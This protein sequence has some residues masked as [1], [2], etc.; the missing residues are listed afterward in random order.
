MCQP[1]ANNEPETRRVIIAGAGP[2]GLLLQALLHNRNKAT[3]ARV[4]YNV[5]MIESRADLGQLNNEELQAHRSWMIGLAG[6]GLEAIKS[7]PD[8]YEKYCSDVGI[9]VTEGNVFLGSKK[10]SMGGGGNELDNGENFIVDRNFIVAAL[11]RYA[12]DHL[13]DSPFYAAKYDTEMLYVDYENRRV[14]VRNKTTKEEEY[15]PYDLLVGADGIRSTVREALVK[16]H[17]DFELQVGDIFQTFKAVHVQRPEALSPNS[18]SL[19]PT[20]FPNFN[21]ISLPETGGLINLSMG[22][23]R[24]LFDE[25]PSDLKSDDPSVVEKYFRENFKAFTLSDEAYVELGKQWAGQRWNRTGMVH[26]NR[27]SSLECGIVLMGDSAHATSPSI[28]MG[29]NTALRDAQKFNELLD[30]FQDDLDEVLPQ[31]SKDRVP[32]GNSLT[33]IALNTYCFDA[34][35]GLRTMLSTMARTGLNKLLPFLVAKDYGML[36]GRPEHTLADIYQMATEQGVLRK[37][38]AINQRI[39]H[40]Y[41]E[42]ETGMIKEKP[43]FSMLRRT[44]LV[45]VPVAACAVAAYVKSN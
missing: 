44:A 18:M 15:L 19:L 11:A 9:N 4:T 43:G 23:P 22:V 38:R 30:K 32:E 3:D 7:V 21:G 41:F 34:K 10:I 40:E 17:F 35:V 8:L 36:I 26:C 29:M 14:L 42:R 25:V 45:V 28:G 27:Y 37:H 31:Y 6:H 2:A 39:R 12:K 33:D 13:A 1:P 20:C 16:R 5:T 24:N